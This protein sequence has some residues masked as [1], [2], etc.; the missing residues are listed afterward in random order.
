MKLE[1][2]RLFMQLRF[3]STH[4]DAVSLT[5]NVGTPVVSNQHS[6]SIGRRGSYS[7]SFRTY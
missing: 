2:N 7:H 5:T 3:P 1:N 6:E 4:D